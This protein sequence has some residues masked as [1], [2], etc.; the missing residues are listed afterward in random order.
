MALATFGPSHGRI[1]PTDDN[2]NLFAAQAIGQ[3]GGHDLHRET[4]IEKTERHRE[5][6]RDRETQEERRETG[7]SHCACAGKSSGVQT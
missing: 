5:A 3:L 6:E 2:K 7:E 4:Q 1:L